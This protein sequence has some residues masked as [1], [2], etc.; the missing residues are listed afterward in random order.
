MTVRLLEQSL[1]RGFES[2]QVH[3]LNKFNGLDWF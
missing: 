3:S 1:G 2:R